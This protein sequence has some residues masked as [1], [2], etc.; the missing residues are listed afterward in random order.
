MVE[1][2]F[3]AR[4]CSLHRKT[5]T[6]SRDYYL[7]KPCCLSFL[8]HRYLLPAKI[9]EFSEKEVPQWPV[10]WNRKMQNLAT[11]LWL[12]CCFLSNFILTI[13]D[14]Y[15]KVAT[16]QR[17]PTYSSPRFPKCFHFTVV[18][19]HPSFLSLCICICIHIYVCVYI[20]V[21]VCIYIY[22]YMYKHTFFFWIA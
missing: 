20:C 9:S 1:C 19:F 14:L 8:N 18:L 13:L 4:L 3:F 16:V 12:C 15:R 6:I 21:C 11:F 2:S 7:L 10:T 5:S 22:M 17:L